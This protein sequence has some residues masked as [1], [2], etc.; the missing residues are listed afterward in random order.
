MNVSHNLCVVMT[1]L[2]FSSFA[3]DALYLGID[4]SG[5]GELG[6]YPVVAI[7]E[8]PLGGWQDKHKTEMIVLRRV[9]PGQFVMWSDG[10]YDRAATNATNPHLVT[11]S[12]PYYIGVFEVT[13]RQY[14]LVTGVPLAATS[15]RNPMAAVDCVSWASIRGVTNYES[16]IA[17]RYD[18]PKGRDVAPESFIG[19][20][21]K[22]TSYKGIDL[23]T[24]A[25][26][27]YAYRHGK[28][29]NRDDD[30]QP[31]PRSDDV[32]G[33][34]VKTV[35]LGNPNPI[36]LYDM[37]GNALEWCLDKPGG[38]MDSPCIDPVGADHDVH[39]ELQRV[40]R[41]GSSGIRYVEYIGWGQFGFRIVIN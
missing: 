4:L 15:C 25:Q 7:N 8:V 19:L 28:D 26:W 38:G 13:Q 40:L 3:G 12:R 11:I 34:S 18:W 24:E 14:E 2:A 39:G 29:P 1:S 31:R 23:P 22:R 20:L 37:Q 17:K 41:G 9:D 6:R 10:S 21:R 35:G 33:I 16:S 30:L 27:E 32:N 5:G 36:G